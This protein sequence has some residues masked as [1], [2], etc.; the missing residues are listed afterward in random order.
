MAKTTFSN[1]LV[2]KALVLQ[3][4]EAMVNDP[5][6]GY[7]PEQ[8]AYDA[9][10]VAVL[11]SDI[12]EYCKVTQ[13]QLA[14]KAAKAK[15]KAAEKK[16]EGDELRERVKAVLTEEAQT[17]DQVF[18]NFADEEGLTIA[19]IGARLTQL[20]KAGEAE[21]TLEKTADGSKKMTYKLAQ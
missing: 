4:I 2:T 19:K 13:E 7:A 10:G 12:L 20:V 5:E 3:A 17:R 15:T 16:A 8:E 9:N 6:T 21:K 11:Y 14:E 18:A 1:T